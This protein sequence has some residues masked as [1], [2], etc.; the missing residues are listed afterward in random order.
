MSTPSG[1]R[2]P[3]RLVLVVT[4][5]VPGWSMTKAASLWR[6]TV[7]VTGFP[8]GGVVWVLSIS[9]VAPTRLAVQV[10]GFTNE[11]RAHPPLPVLSVRDVDGPVIVTCCPATASP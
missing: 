5:R 11:N 10:P 4:A 9:A 3:D 1:R 2:Y 8:G 6:W 7:T